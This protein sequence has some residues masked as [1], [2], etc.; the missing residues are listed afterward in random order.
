MQDVNGYECTKEIRN[1]EKTNFSGGRVPIIGV[2]ADPGKY[3]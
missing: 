2:S 1:L 3:R